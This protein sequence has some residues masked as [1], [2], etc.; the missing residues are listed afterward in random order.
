L[1]GVA[2]AGA[3]GGAGVCDSTGEPGTGGAP[4]GATI[5][6]P[7]GPITGAGMALASGPA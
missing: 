4:G 2:P 5:G 7:S 6:W 1:N 3:A